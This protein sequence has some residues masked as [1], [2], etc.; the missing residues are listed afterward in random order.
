M[1]YD[2]LF[3]LQFLMFFLQWFSLLL[4]FLLRF[5][6]LLPLLMRFPLTLP[7]FLHILRQLPLPESRLPRNPEGNVSPLSG[8]AYD[9]QLLLIVQPQSLDHIGQPK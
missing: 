9:L 5:S 7:F 6:P 2:S 3:F 8:L 1:L 4:P